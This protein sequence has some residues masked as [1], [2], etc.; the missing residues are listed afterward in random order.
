[1]KKLSVQ[2]KLSF[3]VLFLITY[4]EQFPD[5]IFHFTHTFVA[6]ILECGI[7]FAPD[8]ATVLNF[9][10]LF[11]PRFCLFGKISIKIQKFIGRINGIHRKSP[12]FFY[13]RCWRA[14]NN[15]QRIAI[16]MVGKFFLRN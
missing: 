16:K 11:F 7:S 6:Q 4:L 8:Y 2:Q 10:L 9:S 15:S 13:I 5:C 3:E 1:M 12:N 14:G